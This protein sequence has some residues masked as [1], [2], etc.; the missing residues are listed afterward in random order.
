LALGRA[1]ALSAA[2]AQFPD[3]SISQP[4]ADELLEWGLAPAIA[5]QAVELQGVVAGQQVGDG[6]QVDGGEHCRPSLRLNRAQGV[7]LA[8]VAAVECR[9][10]VVGDALALIPY[11]ETAA[12]RQD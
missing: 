8:F 9:G 11:L 7:S 12:S 2:K 10:A 3:R 5:A 6:V 1:A 4:A